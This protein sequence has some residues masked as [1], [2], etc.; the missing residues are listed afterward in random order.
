MPNCLLYVF[1][2]PLLTH[3]THLFA[4]HLA[5]RL[6]LLDRLG[7]AKDGHHGAAPHQVLLFIPGVRRR[8]RLLVHEFVD[9]PGGGGGGRVG[10]QRVGSFTNLDFEM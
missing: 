1:E 9:V 3:V 8:L 10:R 5:L 7:L 6:G 2:R 4:V